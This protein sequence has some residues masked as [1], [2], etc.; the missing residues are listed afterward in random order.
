MTLRTDFT[1]ALKKAMLARDE[2]TTGTVRM[3]MAKLKDSDIA[4]RS[5]GNMNGIGETEILT[6]LHGMIKQR[7]ESIALYQK[8]GRLDLVNQE[9]AEITVIERFLPKQMDENEMV[10][11]I[12][13]IITTI[14]A[15]DIK[16]M[17]RVMG[18][19]KKNFAGKMDFAHAGSLVKG[20]LGGT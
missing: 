6:M 1:D 2:R 9:S 8:G 3:I 12:T 7:R 16:D 19:L 18:E 5:K 10:A 17:G 14:G 15:K 13:Q 11:A 20:Q 4:A